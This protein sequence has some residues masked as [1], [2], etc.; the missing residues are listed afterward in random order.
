MAFSNSVS[1]HVGGPEKQRAFAEEARRLASGYWVQTPSDRFPIEAHTGFPYFW[2]LPE[3]LRGK[4]MERWRQRLPAWTEMMAGTTVISRQRMLE[5]FPDGKL[6]IERRFGLEKSY[7]V[8]RECG[9][10]S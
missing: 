4:L 9:R 10:R 3:S 1:E 7:A 8:W 5:L 2:R 6:F